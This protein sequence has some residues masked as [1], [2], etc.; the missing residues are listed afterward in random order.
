MMRA[1]TVFLIAAASLALAAP[2]SAQLAAANRPDVADLLDYPQPF[3]TKA[4]VDSVAYHWLEWERDPVVESQFFCLDGR[5]VEVEG[6]GRVAQV[7]L[8]TPV[9]NSE[10][11]RGKWTL[12]GLAFLPPGDFSD[13]EVM[14]KA[15]LVLATRPYWR[16]FGFVSGHDL[17]SGSHWCANI[18]DAGADGES[19]T[20]TGTN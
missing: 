9:V 19:S 12:G 3:V 7:E 13:E 18:K 6:Y 1:P 2:A 8:V 10:F 5:V 17:S 4:V 14:E 16:L 20:E 11:C 15:C